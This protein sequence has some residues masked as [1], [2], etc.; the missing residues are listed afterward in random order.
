MIRLLALVAL[1][2]LV[3]V[4]S[5]CN[6]AGA[7]AAITRPDPVDKAKFVL[8][9]VPTVVL[10]DDYFT[11]VGMTRLRREIAEEATVVLMERDAVSHMISPLDALRAA[12]QLDQ[13]SDKVGARVAISDVGQA[14]GADQVIYIEPVKFLVPR[15]SGVADPVATYRVKVIDAASRT[16][17]W[18]SD[19]D[20]GSAGWPV[21]V[22]LSRDEAVGLS[23]DGPHAVA[24][25]LAT[26]SGDAIARLFIDT[27]YSQH[28]NRLLGQ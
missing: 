22:S 2:A 26:E 11:V 20:G 4:Q 28:G 5:G 19:E 1:A 27:H 17:L 13:K 12:R 14:V 23:A 25:R 21:R 6:I 9:D 7:V 15:L 10:F 18:P 24:E 8:G 16:R 3:S